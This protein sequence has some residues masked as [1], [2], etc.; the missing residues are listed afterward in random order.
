MTVT[1]EYVQKLI[2][3]LKNKKAADPF[4]ICAEHIKYADSA[5]TSVITTITNRTLIEQ[6]VPKDLKLGVITPVLKKQKQKTDPNN[7]QR[8]TVNSMIWKK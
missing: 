8:I 5:I 3:S 2:N 6:Q 7:Y 1:T 4:G